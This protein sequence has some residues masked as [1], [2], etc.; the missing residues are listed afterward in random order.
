[1]NCYGDDS[2]PKIPKWALKLIKTN[3][4]LTKNQYFKYLQFHWPIATDYR[5]MTLSHKDVL[6]LNF[7]N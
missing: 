3:L 4:T 5:G 1:M 6:P 7:L 2:Q